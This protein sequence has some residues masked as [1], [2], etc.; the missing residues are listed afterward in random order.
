MENLINYI[1]GVATEGFVVGALFWCISYITIESTS[2][3]GA[4]RAGWISELVG[5][6]PYLFGI[7]ALGA[8]ALAMTVVGGFIFIR[9]ILRVGEL[10]PLKAT[11]GVAMTYFALIAIV[12]CA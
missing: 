11:Y 9:M 1:V 12:A 3:R 5:N 6:I 4:L 10:T 7:D 2:L 8:P